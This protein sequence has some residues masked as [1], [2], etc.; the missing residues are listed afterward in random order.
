MLQEDNPKKSATTQKNQQQQQ[1]FIRF[2]K[3]HRYN[4]NDKFKI[5]LRVPRFSLDNL[6]SFRALA[7]IT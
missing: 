1:P 5:I 7:K 2:F 3:T 6:G 4:K